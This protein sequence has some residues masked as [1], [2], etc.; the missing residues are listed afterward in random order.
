MAW[1]YSHMISGRV[2]LPDFPYATMLSMV[3][4]IG[5]TMSDAF[6]PPSTQLPTMSV[7]G[8]PPRVQCS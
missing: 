1:L 7:A 2:P 6:T 8:R 4:Y 5:H 3:A